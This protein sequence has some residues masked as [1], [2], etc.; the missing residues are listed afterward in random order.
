MVEVGSY[1]DELRNG[2]HSFE[3]IE[4][5]SNAVILHSGGVASELGCKELMLEA[6]Q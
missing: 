5:E 3:W 1:I 2:Q 6:D 4:R